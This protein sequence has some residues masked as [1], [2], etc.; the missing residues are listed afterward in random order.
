MDTRSQLISLRGLA[1][2]LNHKEPLN[3]K[4]VIIPLIQRNYKWGVE[5]KEKERATA[6]NLFKCLINAKKENKNEYTIGM[7]SLYEDKKGVQI[8]DG[9]QR[10]I[11]LSILIKALGFIGDFIRIEF[12]RDTEKKERISFL[13]G[14]ENGDCVEVSAESVDVRHM[15]E[16]YNKF[17]RMCIEEFQR[18]EEKEEMYNWMLDHIKMICRYTE[19]EPLQEFLNINENKTEF[20]STDYDRAYRVCESFSVNEIS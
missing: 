1:E 8:I 13:Y 20:S 6:E 14:C 12:E 5:I 16:T 7:I 3:N 17:I 19:N 11:T 15:Q 4:R 2:E 10:L 18:S 9:Q